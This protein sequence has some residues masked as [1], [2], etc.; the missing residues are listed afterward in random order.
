[1]AAVAVTMMTAEI[2]G[3]SREFSSL[4]IQGA[5]SPNAIAAAEEEEEQ[6]NRDRQ[7]TGR[8]CCGELEIVLCS[9]CK[10]NCVHGRRP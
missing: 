4:V 9:S 7:R 3:M 1:M 5:V 6:G 2:R 8:G 10:F